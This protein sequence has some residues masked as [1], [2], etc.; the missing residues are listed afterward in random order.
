MVKLLSHMALSVLLVLTSAGM[1]INMHYCQGHL[2]DMAFN[3]P[4]HSCC[5]P[6]GKTH[7]CHHDHAQPVKHHCEDESV[8]VKSTGDYLGSAFSFPFENNHSNDLLFITL[9]LDETPGEADFTSRFHLRDKKPPPTQ[10]VELSRL[11]RFLI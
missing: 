8:T 11:Q 5:E 3:A 4:A 1:T 9:L 6:D 10:E 7:S 2:Y